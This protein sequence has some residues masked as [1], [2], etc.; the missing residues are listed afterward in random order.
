[1]ACCCG[2]ALPCNGCAPASVL[3]N[4]TVGAIND[5]PSQPGAS[6]T[7]LSFWQAFPCVAKAQAL[8]GA[9]SLSYSEFYSSLI[10]PRISYVYEDGIVFL[11]LRLSC[12]NSSYS[13]LFNNTARCGPV[14]GSGGFS[15]H[16]C[17][18]NTDL[19]N[20]NLFVA[21]N[22]NAGLSARCSGVAISGAGSGLKAYTIALP[23]TAANP[24]FCQ[25]AASGSQPNGYW[26]SHDFSFTV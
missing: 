6:N 20:A 13:F 8:S 19:S 1:M 15:A 10:R 24:D 3:V 2:P 26:L 12:S 18:Q 14:I 7:V 11:E 25:N 22:T 23:P 16:R 21:G 5:P 9:Y 4:L 17:F